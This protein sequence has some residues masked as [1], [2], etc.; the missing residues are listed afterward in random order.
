MLFKILHGDSSRISLDITPFHEGYCYVT[1]DGY[2]YVDMNI[3]TEEEP[4]NQRVK[5]SADDAQTVLGKDIA[6]VLRDSEV[7]IPTSKAVW[8]AIQEISSNVI[9][10]NDLID[11]PFGEVTEEAE[12]VPATTFTDNGSVEFVTGGFLLEDGK[13][14]LVDWDGTKYTCVGMPANVY[15]Y[16]LV[17]V[18]NLELV[19][20]SGGNG[21]PFVVG[22]VIEDGSYAVAASTTGDHTFR[23]LGE[24]TVLKT[25]DPKYIKDMYYENVE[26]TTGPLNISWDGNVDGREYHAVTEVEGMQ[27]SLCKVSNT[28]LTLSD[29]S[30]GT[31]TMVTPG[32]TQT[33]PIGADTAPAVD[34]I[35]LFGVA[36]V[37]VLQGEMPY[38]VSL[39]EGGEV[40]GV[41]ASKGTYFLE[42]K[43]AGA[44][45]IYTSNVSNPDAIVTDR[46]EM[47]KT[48]DP[49]YIKDMYYEEGGM[50]RIDPSTMDLSTLV[51]SSDRK[52]YRVSELTPSVD[53]FLTWYIETQGARVTVAQYENVAGGTIKDQSDSLY[54]FAFRTTFIVLSDGAAYGDCVFPE[55]GVYIDYNN[56]DGNIVFEANNIVVHKIPSKYIELPD[57]VMRQAYELPNTANGFTLLMADI[58]D[59]WE[60]NGVVAVIYNGIYYSVLGFD[61]DLYDGMS[62]F[63]LARA[64]NHLPKGAPADF[65]LYTL[66]YDVINSQI[67]AVLKPVLNCK[68]LYLDSSTANSNKRFKITV[69][70]NSIHILDTD[71]N[72]VW[73]GVT[74]KVVS[75]DSTN[76]ITSGAVYDAIAGIDVPVKSV[77]GETG[78]VTL[79]ASDVGAADKDHNHVIADI[80]NFPDSMKNPTALTVGSK[81]YDGSS[82]VSITKSD[83]GLGNVEN[84][85]SATIRSE[86]TK[87]NVTGA[88]GYTPPTKDTTYGTASSTAAGLVKVGYEE[89][90]KNYPVELDEGKMFVNVPWTDTKYTHPTTEGN[91]HLPAGGAEGQ[92]LRWSASGTAEWGD[93][94]DTIYTLPAAGTELGG[95]KTGGDVTITNGVIAVNDDSHNHVIG[96]VDGL[97]TALN[98]KSETGHKHST[99]DITNFPTTLPNEKA[100]TIQLNSGTTEGTN[101]FTY[102]GSEAK[103]VNVTKSSI[104]LGNVDNKSS[105]TIRGEITSDNVTTALGFTPMNAALKGTTNGV[106]ELDSSGKVPSSQLPSYVDDTV[107]GYFYNNKFYKES[108]H[109]T[110]ITG[111]TGKIYVDLSANKTYRW[112]GSAFVEISASLA[113]GETSSTAYRGDR[114]KVAY[115]HAVSAHNY[116]AKGH[117]H[118]VSHTPA[119]SVSSSFTGT[120]H[121]HTFT[122]TAVNS[123]ATPSASTTTVYSITDLGALP[124]ATLNKGTLPSLTFDEGELPS[125]TFNPG[126]HSFN[127]GKLPSAT[128]SKG[129]LPSLTFDPG[130]LPSATFNPGSHSFSAGTLPSASLKAGSHS[131]SAGTLPTLTASC[132]NQRLT[133]TFNQG[134]LPSASHTDPTLTF[135]AGTLP[136]HTY[137]APSL[138]FDAGELPSATFG[139][140]TLPSLTFDAGTLPS[141]SFTA[142]SLDFDAGELP[143][144][145]FGA[146]TLPSLTFNAGTLPSRSGVT[147]PKSDHKHSVTVAGTISDTTAGGSV[148]SSFTGTAATLTTSADS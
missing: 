105:A 143:S 61:C 59:A 112:S 57:S 115:D 38:V 4:N 51:T 67:S 92:I 48:I 68:E 134:T 10:W 66:R 31:L 19:G 85:S 104:G 54:S 120:A 136:S 116:S 43:N 94:E 90:G 118:S 70:D 73:S 93:D 95:V 100:L 128:L 12:F 74:D 147:V 137:T 32:G 76:L 36:G 109:T 25:I 11:R 89:N 6:D 58:R 18:G 41:Q 69:D 126:S 101:K 84:K 52:F 133:L 141:S 44:T 72:V 79:V 97:Q 27:V 114:G 2:M 46:K 26:E 34:L 108:G 132:T 30:A 45:Y 62:T 60:K 125:A 40:L 123:D 103:S 71:G 33:V 39:S 42:V 131:F 87:E 121:D 9:S 111:E 55:A 5:L 47:I 3:G 22:C 77:N 50:V 83:L 107:E 53:E 138:T 102:T 144:A 117:K 64:L 75:A 7:E 106:A 21:E 110:A 96:N 142:P 65:S 124:S 119:G 8:D 35:D 140:G 56:V 130:E 28:V 135:S 127:A 129:S 29:L 16:D 145:T 80:T 49:K 63:L 113:L 17:A 86:L 14:Y 148:S 37:G 122:G 78:D 88:L 99:G 139:A 23:I 15:G 98:G 82:A 81:T 13:T 1:H 24:A 91:K 20:V 146:G